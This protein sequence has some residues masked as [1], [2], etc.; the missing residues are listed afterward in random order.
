MSLKSFLVQLSRN[1]RGAST[2][3]FGLICAMIIIA[4]LGALRGFTETSIDMWNNVASRMEEAIS[5]ST[6]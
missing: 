4:M 3:E 1:A 6:S 2:I 5:N